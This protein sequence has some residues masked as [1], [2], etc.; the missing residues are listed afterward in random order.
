[1]DS[2]SVKEKFQMGNFK[3]LKQIVPKFVGHFDLEGQCQG[4]KF[5]E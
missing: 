3:S 5:L 4:H 2:L 1:M